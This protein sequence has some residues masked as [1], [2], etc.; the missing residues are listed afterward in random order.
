HVE[1]EGKLDHN[2]F[3]LTSPVQGAITVQPQ[4]MPALNK[5]QS[6]ATIQFSLNELNFPVPL[7]DPSQ[8]SSRGQIDIRAGTEI[9]ANILARIDGP[10]FQGKGSFRSSDLTLDSL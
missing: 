6:P 10:R 9:N 5:I 2:R 7:N 1:G 3:L 4:A 8:V